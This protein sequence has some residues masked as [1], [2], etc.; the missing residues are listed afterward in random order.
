MSASFAPA[1]AQNRLLTSRRLLGN[2]RTFM[3][4]PQLN[5]LWHKTSARLQKLWRRK[6]W[7]RRVAI[8][9]FG[10]HRIVE[11]HKGGCCT[12]SNKYANANALNYGDYKQAYKHAQANE[13]NYLQSLYLPIYALFTC[14]I[15]GVISCDV[16]TC[17]IGWK[18]TRCTGFSRFLVQYFRPPI[19]RD[20]A[21]K[22]AE[23]PT[24]NSLG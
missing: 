23:E 8:C 9:D 7:F 18:P 5:S 2:C 10:E 24:T 12:P 16:I 3:C 4:H 11:W 1:P 13:A 22:K 21:D 20:W 15:L 17:W 14:F 6:C 19:L